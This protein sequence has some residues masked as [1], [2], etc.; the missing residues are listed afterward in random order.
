MVLYN[1]ISKKKEVY[2]MIT[3]LKK[4]SILMLFVIMIF[5]LF[6]C[7]DEAKAVMTLLNGVEKDGVYSISVPSATESVD[8]NDYI[9]VS[10]DAKWKLYS[11][12]EQENEI[13]SSTVALNIGVNQF[14]VRVKEGTTKKSYTIQ[15]VRKKSITV[16]FDANGGSA[17]QEIVVDEGTIVTIPT[18]TRVGYDFAGWDIDFT[19]PVTDNTT[20]KA[21]WNAKTFKLTVDGEESVVKFG[22]EFSLT[23]KDK[24]GYKFVKWIDANNQ[25]FSASGK[26]DALTDV[27][28]TSV[29]TKENYKLTFIFNADIAN[30]V[31]SY[32]V[33]D[34]VT[35]ETPIHPNGLEFD[36]WYSEPELKNKV[37]EIKKGT[38]GNKTLYA[39]W[40]HEEPTYTVTIDADGFSFDGTVLTLKYGQEYKLPDVPARNGYDF[41]AW[42]DQDGNTISTSG[43]WGVP[44]NTTLTIKWNV[45]SY[46]VKYIANAD[47]SIENGTYTILS[48][49]TLP[50]PVHPSGLE[51]LGWYSDE[52]LSNKVESIEIGEYGAKTLYASWKEIIIPEEEEYEILIDAEGCDFDK[53]VISVKYGDSYT[54][55]EVTD[56][57]GYTYTWMNGEAQISASGTWKIKED[58]TITLKWTAIEY[59]INYVFNASIDEKTDKYTIEDEFI[60]PIPTHP[61][62]LEFDGWYADSGLTQRVEKIEKGSTEDKTFYGKWLPKIEEYEIIIDAV[63]FEAGTTIKVIY[64]EEYTLPA[65][66][67]RLGYDF[68][69][70]MNGTEIVPTSGVWTLHDNATLTIKWNPTTY[71]IQ[72]IIDGKTQNP[73]TTNSFTINDAVAL[74]DPTRP[75]ATFVGW[76]TSPDFSEASKITEIATGTAKD[77]VLYA[78]FDITTYTITFDAN[79]GTVSK[80]SVTYEKGDTYVLPTPEYPGY[81]FA[82]WY[83]GEDKFE[84]GEWTLETNITL[85]ASWTRVLYLVEYNFNGG[86]TTETL[87]QAYSVQDTFTL[88]IPTK[89]GYFFLGWS[90]EGSGKIY[91]T[92]TIQTGTTGN[93]KFIANW[94][95]FSFSFSGDEAIVTG[96]KVISSR[97]FVKIPTTV[98]YDGVDY[99]VTEIGPNVFN[100]IGPLIKKGYFIV[101][102]NLVRKFD[103]DV[104]KTLKRIGI[105]AFTD[106]N[107]VCINVVLDSGVDLYEWADSLTVAEGNDHVVDVIKG[108][109]PA[110]GWSVY[111]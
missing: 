66:P 99:T 85:V 98:N 94:S 53:Q 72:Y 16:S 71:H 19:V 8:L 15:I 74:L 95:E 38:T 1:K 80:D 107:D 58:A 89:E 91:K 34:L 108:R 109:R 35:F 42:I 62:G 59:D 29:Y 32:T 69:A 105:N 12:E 17:C 76:Y 49:L 14:Y 50:V 56:R 81:K 88:P 25:E 6:S 78:K 27:S 47:I 48:G 73:N 57:V 54:L 83:Y 64:G 36:G 92:M 106:C 9:T 33:E 21:K 39:K 45:K 37:T 68:V 82:G 77:I 70:W 90:E 67:E 93:K 104:P 40:I 55:P 75:N 111:G 23:P 43:N 46:V 103:V 22:E 2:F 10:D 86:S 26:W 101:G 60:L 7:E 20:A 100:G 51:F 41:V 31:S 13:E 18:T 44:G 87:R 11:D 84:D 4:L 28:V 52:N 3:K 61:D 102:G 110:I 65:V 79:G 24:L 63:G 5:S 97:A 96:Y 30:K